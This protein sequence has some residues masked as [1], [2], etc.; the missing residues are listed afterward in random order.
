[1]DEAS[2]QRQAAEQANQAKSEFLSRMSH[3][4]RTPLNAM[5]GFAQVMT[6]DRTQ[7]L[8]DSQRARLDQIQH[9]GWHLLDMIDDVLDLSRIDTGT[10][11]LQ[12]DQLQLL[13]VLTLTLPLI[14]ELAHKHKVRL[15]VDGTLP[16]GVGVLADETRLRQVLTNLMSNAVKYNRPGGSVRVQAASFK[17]GG[18]SWVRVVVSDTGLGMDDD[19][20][21]Q[22]FQPFNR[23]GRERNQPDGTG[24]GLVISRH[25]TQLMGGSM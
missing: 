13:Q 1:M 21:A 23:L 8:H 11:R 4:L 14:E 24:I 15:T 5:L 12:V 20:L 2:Q 22:L 19:Q 10:L 6:L 9:A 25:L 18:Q 3:E 16:P 17:Q 7:P